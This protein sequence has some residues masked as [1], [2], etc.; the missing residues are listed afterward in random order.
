MR[1]VG[2]KV[3]I[4][5]LENFVKVFEKTVARMTEEVCHVKLKWVVRY[6]TKRLRL[7][8][9]KH[10]ATRPLRNATIQLKRKYFQSVILHCCLMTYFDNSHL[11]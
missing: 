1:E 10:H 11:V 2:L 6:V 3:N 8:Y 9:G 5:D 7:L 4:R